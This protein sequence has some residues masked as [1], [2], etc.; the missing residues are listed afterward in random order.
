MVGVHVQ[1]QRGLQEHD[2]S[3]RHFLQLTDKRWQSGHSIFPGSCAVVEAEDLS[4]VQEAYFSFKLP[5]W[6]VARG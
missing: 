2:S 5:F 4:G 3:D 1:S 6:E